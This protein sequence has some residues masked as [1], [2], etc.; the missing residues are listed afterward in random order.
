MLATGGVTIQQA[1]IDID[2]LRFRDRSRHASGM[3]GRGGI[4]ANPRIRHDEQHAAGGKQPFFDELRV[5]VWVSEPEYALGVREERESPAEGLA[6]DIYFN[7]LDYFHELGVQT[8]GEPWDEPG[9][10]VPLVHVAPGEPPRAKVT[11]LRYD[12][13][14]TTYTPVP[15]EQRIGGRR[16]GRSRNRRELARPAGVRQPAARRDGARCRAVVS[17]AD[18]CGN[19]GRQAGWGGGA[20]ADETG[21]DEAD[22]PDRR[23]APRQRGGEHDGRLPLRRTARDRPRDDAAPRPLQHRRHPG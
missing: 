10:I 14:K 3:H 20:L 1:G 11:L 18:D 21:G 12:A 5:E 23:A 15:V 13:A 6:E 17:R 4:A 22:A 9:Q 2:L 16:D 19:R 7:T 8:T